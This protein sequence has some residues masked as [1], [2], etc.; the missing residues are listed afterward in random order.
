MEK[1][2]NKW[3]DLLIVEVDETGKTS[4]KYR[5]DILKEETKILREI[6]GV[7]I[8]SDHFRNLTIYHL[9]AAIQSYQITDLS[10]L[11][12]LRQ[13]IVTGIVD[14]DAEDLASWLS[15][16]KERFFY[17]DEVLK[18]AEKGLFMLEVLIKAQFSE[19]DEILDNLIR[20]LKKN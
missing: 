19:I 1:E 9:L 7:E 10:R 11:L 4:V 16:S 20:C 18:T 12:E 14:V 15:S 8:P 13:E 5:A 3:L 6:H 17:C 2:V